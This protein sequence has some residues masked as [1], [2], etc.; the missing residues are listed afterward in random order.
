VR[1]LNPGGTF[2]FSTPIGPQRVEFNAHRVFSIQYLLELFKPHL[3]VTE[4]SY[5][6]DGGKF[7]QDIELSIKI[8]ESNAGCWFGCGMFK[9][10]KRF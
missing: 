1:L 7:H 8:I 6:D 9:L 5:V 4:F 2:Y 3:E 10:R